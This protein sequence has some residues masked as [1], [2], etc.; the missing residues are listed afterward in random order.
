[1]GGSQFQMILVG[2]RSSEEFLKRPFKGGSTFDTI[3]H[4]HKIEIDSLG[5]IIL[6]E[7]GGSRGI[8][9]CPC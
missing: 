6:D 7:I 5:L 9:G 3:S 1:M 8:F 4:W 2:E